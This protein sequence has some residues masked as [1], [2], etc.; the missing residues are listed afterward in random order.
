MYVGWYLCVPKMSFSTLATIIAVTAHM[1]LGYALDCCSNLTAALGSKVAYPG[2]S[3]YNETNSY[4]AAQQTSLSPA[5]VVRPAN[6]DDVSLAL[7]TLIHDSCMFAVRGGGHSSTK[8][9]S[10]IEGGVTIDMRGLNSTTLNEDHTLATVGGGQV[11]GGAYSALYQAGVTV[12]GGRDSGIGV[13]GSVVGGA[14]GYIAPSTGFGCDSVVEF[15]VVLANGSI[16]SATK[17]V[18]ND[19]W[20]SLKGGG[21]NFGILTKLVIST[22]PIGEIWTS[23]SAYDISAKD[24][25]IQAFYDF[26][27]NPDYDP[28]ADLLMNYFYSPSSGFQFA[29]LYAYAEPIEKPA[30]FDSFYSIQGQIG[31][32][33]NVTTV[34]DYSVNQDGTSPAGFQQITFAISFKNNLQQL[35]DVLTVFND[36]IPS[37]EDIAGISWS[38]TLEPIPTSLGAASKARG[39]NSLG[40]EVPPEGIVLTVAS[41]TFNSSDDFPVVQSAALKLLNDII[42]AAEKNDAQNSFIDL[43]HAHRSQ[44]PF[45]SYGADNYQFLKTTADKYD[46]TGV[47]Q[48]L[49]PGGF[50]L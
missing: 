6:A 44:N 12:P 38:L 49:M 26:V 21:S 4:W 13:A 35:K 39:G 8:G 11:W 9:V 45:K 25:V 30:A 43:D 28:K 33:S 36:S 46:P 17:N 1:G 20:R 14:L 32:V 3:L 31:N 47:F 7:V 34:P 2:S 27:A 19:L 42:G 29:N 16:V 48:M 5:C 15:E 40:I 50:K 41:I 23:S 37:I 18:N 24:G 10:N 22:T